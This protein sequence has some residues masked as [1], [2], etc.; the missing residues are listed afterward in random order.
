VR[1][2]R[3]S[4]LAV[5][6]LALATGCSQEK[7]SPEAERGRQVYQAQCIACHNADPS[8]PGALGP[9]VRGSSEE[10]L[11]AKVLNGTYPPGYAPK[12]PTKLM[13]PMPHLANDIPALAAYLTSRP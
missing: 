6:A 7:L 13:Q 11:R 1:R 8:Q 3:L 4:A 9:A 12:R 5:L 2:L 10:L